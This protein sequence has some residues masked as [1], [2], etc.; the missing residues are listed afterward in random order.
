M[1]STK[2]R[3][4]QLKII[5]ERENSKNAGENFDAEADLKKS[6]EEREAYRKGA[7]LRT[8]APNLVDPDDRNML[9]G[10]NQESGHHKKRADD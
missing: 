8:D 5:E 7:N 9:R 2:T 1:A 3:E 10:E 6:R 4:Q